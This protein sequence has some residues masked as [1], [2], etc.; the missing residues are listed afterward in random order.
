MLY[1]EEI[2]SET[3]TSE[4]LSECVKRKFFTRLETLLRNA[5]ADVIKF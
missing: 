3:I 1:E 5:N 2:L 4:K